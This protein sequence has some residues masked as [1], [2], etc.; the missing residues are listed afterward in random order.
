MAIE[1][2][3][4]SSSSSPHY[5]PLSVSATL[6]LASWVAELHT[7]YITEGIIFTIL[8]LVFASN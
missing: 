6:K 7:V 4:T 2:R 3:A 5:Q 1:A 8:L